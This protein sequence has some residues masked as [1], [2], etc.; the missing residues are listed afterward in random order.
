MKLNGV[1]RGFLIGMIDEWHED[2]MRHL[3]LV[4]L[5]DDGVSYLAMTDDRQFFEQI[6]SGFLADAPDGLVFPFVG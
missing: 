1:Y 3:E 2:Q 5:R 6:R 4:A